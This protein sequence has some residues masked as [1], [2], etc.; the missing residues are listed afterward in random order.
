MHKVEIVA[1]REV[2][3]NDLP[4]FTAL[5]EKNSSIER[6][7]T[8]MN[9]P[10]ER[11]V[12]RVFERQSAQR[13][14]AMAVEASRAYW[15]E[16]LADLPPAPE[17]PIRK[18][19]LLVP[20]PHFVH[21]EMRVDPPI[22][23]AI[24][25]RARQCHLSPSAVL[26][27]CYA[28]ILSVWSAQPDITINLSLFDRGLIPPVNRVL[29]DFTALALVAY[30]PIAGE[31]WLAAMLRLQGQIGRDLEQRNIPTEWILQEFG[32][33]FEVSQ[34]MMPVVPPNALGLTNA[35]RKEA[36]P[37]TACMWGITPSPQLWIDYQAAEAADGEALLH[38]GAVDDL[39]A[40]GVS[41]A[42]FEAYGRLLEWLSR[43]DWSGPVCELLPTAQ[44]GVRARVNATQGPESGRLLY[45]GFL[46]QVEQAPQRIALLWGD[47]KEMTYGELWAWAARI[48]SLLVS[49][50]VAPGEPVGVTLPKGPEQIA[51]V[52]GVLWA[53]G[54]YVPI[55][56]NQPKLRRNRICSKAGVHVVL[57][58]DAERMSGW[59]CDV[60][61]LGVKEAAKTAPLSAPRRVSIELGAYVIFTSGSTGEPKG[62]EVSHRAAANTVEDI[63]ARFG[64]G[65]SDRV[66]AVS[67]L[68]FDLSVYDI[69]GL[70]SAGGAV[71]IPEEED[72]REARRWMELVQRC[73]V[74]VWNSV[75]ALLNMLL[76]VTPQGCS[77]G[78]RL[79][80]VSGDWVGLD[81]PERLKARWPA[82]RFI[83]LGGATEAAI[84]SN[85]FE[86]KRVAPSW[87]SIPYGYPLRNQCFRVTDPRGRDCPDW[88][89]GELLIGGV[90]LA[91]GYRGDPEITARRFVE[92]GGR[93][94]Y[95]TGDLGRYWPDGTLE[96]LGRIDSQLKIRGFRIEPNEIEAALK[97]NPATQDALVASR[98]DKWGDK[99]LVAYVAGDRSRLKAAELRDLLKS[100]LPD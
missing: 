81:L 7:R 24:T 29:G 56:N 27:S 46:A 98:Q 43:T 75:P 36:L 90:G 92:A 10:P 2:C 21:R 88:V 82:C 26:L 70:L 32:R 47:G 33:R 63:N 77:G 28:E 65:Q 60:K 58:G 25:E 6:N 84:W 34:V 78:L 59:P 18:D 96:F 5:K 91:R 89:A 9:F 83:A 97:E 23:R 4:I 15:K 62:V 45:E 49:R 55:G 13:P 80:L 3:T 8:Q 79:A 52:L 42:M 16:R 38:W 74:T 61:V 95:R 31:S 40:E 94:W 19:P 14:E 85:A 99:R 57:C 50:G 48:A 86:V 20:E 17:L 73:R 69:F 64:V 68:D 11:G 93:R 12:D 39:F 41:D 67:A 44:R 87:R 22:W 35:I 53:G 72:R 66:L 76:L 71:V 100:R 1:E 30:Q 54:M 51:A 37:S